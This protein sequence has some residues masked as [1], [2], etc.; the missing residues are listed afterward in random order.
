MTSDPPGR[1]VP[2]VVRQGA[3]ALPAVEGAVMGAPPAAAGVLR[4]ASWNMTHWT[5]AKVER[6]Q[7]AL[8]FHLIGLQETHLASLPLEYAQSTAR[9]VGFRLHHGRP[10]AYTSSGMFGRTCGVGFLARDGVAVNPVVPVGAAWRRL[11]GWRRLHAV[12]LPPRP[13]LP[14]GV[15][16]VTIYAPL[17]GHDQAAEKA[18]FNA[19]LLEMTFALDMQV[20]TLLIGDFNGSTCPPRDYCSTSGRGRPACEL[21]NKLLGLGST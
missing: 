2:G 8:D 15:L 7:D 9:R 16:V 10:A 21:L 6:L 5:A 20:P 19:A 14:H 1:R 4:I 18:A 17:Q 13:G 3:E 11:H 12:R